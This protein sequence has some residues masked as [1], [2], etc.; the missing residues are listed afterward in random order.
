MAGLIDAD[1]AIIA[2]IE[3][4]AEKKFKFR[5]RVI[6][7]VT[8]KDQDILIWLKET[9]QFG[10]VVKNR[11][12]FDWIL[13]YQRHA[14]IFLEMIKPFIRGKTNQ[15]ELA[16]RILSTPVETYQD[17]ISVAQLADTLASFN[18]R[19]KNRRKNYVSKIQETVSRN[20]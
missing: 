5:V 1:G 15:L 4:H 7:K 20:D 16:L 3:S 2:S 10:R 19:S 12:V 18:V 8:Q 14:L 6:I 11:T 17:L 9:T 13:R